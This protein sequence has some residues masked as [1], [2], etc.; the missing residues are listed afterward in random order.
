MLPDAVSEAI[1]RNKFYEF[2]TSLAIIRALRPGD[3]FVDI[4]AHVGYFTTLA[5][6]LVGSTGIVIAFEPTPATYTYLQHNTQE[7][8]NVQA[9]NA[10]VFESSCEIELRDFGPGWAAF[11]S[12]IGDRRDAKYRRLPT[13]YRVQAVSLDAHASANVYVPSMVKIDAESAEMFILRGMKRILKID[14]PIVIMEVGDYGDDGPRTR[15]LLNYIRDA[16]Y[17]VMDPTASGLTLHS[18]QDHYTY[19]NV[20]CVPR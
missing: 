8:T 9:Y 17:T 11:N 5:S 14:R 4:G 13:R 18:L 1:L 16:G 3:C 20:V 7:L 19:A 6:M 2:E 12:L 15:D 10:A